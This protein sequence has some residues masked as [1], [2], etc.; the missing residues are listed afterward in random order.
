MSDITHTRTTFYRRWNISHTVKN[1]WEPKDMTISATY[2]D[3]KEPTQDQMVRL[4]HQSIAEAQQAC[5]E[6]NAQNAE[7]TRIRK[8]AA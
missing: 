6:L 3:G 8:Q 5:D 2:E 4:A 7:I 1:G